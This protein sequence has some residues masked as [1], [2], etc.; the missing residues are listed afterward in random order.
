MIAISLAG[1]IRI[2]CGRLIPLFLFLL[3]CGCHP[4]SLLPPLVFQDNDRPLKPGDIIDTRSGE[5]IT[6]ESLAERLA[7]VQVIYVGETHTSLE[8][9]RIQLQILEGLYRRNPDM[10]L[11]LEMFPRRAQPVLDRYAAGELTEEDFLREVNWAETWGYP[12]QLYR[13]LLAFAR[14]KGLKIIG[15]NAPREVVHKIARQG[16]VSLSQEERR[17]IAESFLT[18]D[19]KHREVLAQEFQRHRQEKI[20][21]FESFYAAQLAWDETMAETLI[22]FLQTLPPASQVLVMIGKGHITDR[23][24]MPPAAWKRLPHSYKTV[25]PVSVDHP[26]RVLGPELADYLWITSPL[27][28]VHPPRLGIQVK[29]L[30]ENQGLEV[31]AVNPGSAAQRAG[32]QVGDVI[33]KIESEVVRTIEDLHQALAKRPP[34]AHFTVR[35]SGKEVTVAVQWGKLNP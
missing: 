31:T 21:D 16:L 10:A 12:F 4:R 24:G 33:V 22:R 26:F 3:L 34:T 18:E 15:L 23:Q 25:V 5:V 19:P 30:P 6:A 32:L 13:P 8:D 1:F 35:R 20:K 11:A 14:D 9:H 27:E 29:T 2:T 17:E 7:G 28:E